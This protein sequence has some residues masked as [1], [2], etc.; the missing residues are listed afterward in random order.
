MKT[1]SAILLAALAVASARADTNI[2]AVLTTA[3]GISY[4]NARIDHTTP[5]Y[6][7]VWYDGGIVHIALTNL[8][9][10]LQKQYPYDTN[11]ATQFL[12][13]EKQK[14][15][16][17]KA[18]QIAA[19]AARQAWLEK[20]AKNAGWIYITSPDYDHPGYYWASINGVSQKIYLKNAPPGLTAAC[21]RFDQA[22]SEAIFS[23]IKRTH[24]TEWTD[25]QGAA[26]AQTVS[27]LIPRVR[28]FDTGQKQSGIP[29]WQFVAKND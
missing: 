2:I 18:A 27:N 11:A 8:P 1:L 6:A 22:E 15:E 26:D 23:S 4:T 13:A 24:S 10:A 5:V 21:G 7:D 20:Q 14:R 12:A 3:D 25:W 16:Q 9:E 17:L 29:I 19:A 28:A